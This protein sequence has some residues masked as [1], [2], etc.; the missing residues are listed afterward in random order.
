VRV[1][2]ECPLMLF[3]LLIKVATLPKILNKN[4]LTYCFKDHLILFKK[5]H[6]LVSKI[7]NSKDLIELDYKDHLILFY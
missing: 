4:K 6:T 2:Y 7:E 3:C 1:L 5:L